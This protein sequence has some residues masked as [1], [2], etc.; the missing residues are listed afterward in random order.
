[1]VRGLFGSFHHAKGQ[2]TRLTWFPQ[3]VPC[4][5]TRRMERHRFGRVEHEFSVTMTALIH[6][7]MVFFFFLASLTEIAPVLSQVDGCLFLFSS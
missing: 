3:D 2:R 1:M 5:A 6:G 4:F 7:K